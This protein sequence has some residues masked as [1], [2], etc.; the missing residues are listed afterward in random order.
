MQDRFHEEIGKGYGLERGEVGSNAKHRTK[1]QWE[2]EQLKQEFE[3]EKTKLSKELTEEKDRLTAEVQPYRELKAGIDEVDSTGKSMPFGYVAVKK[4]NL[5][6]LQEQAKSD[7]TNRDE[8]ET[9]HERS[10]AVSR[11]EQRADQREQQL[12]QRELGLQNMEQQIIERYNRQLRL[13][14]LLEK[15][16]RD[17]K[18]KD[19]QI[20]DL[21][22]E[23]SSLRGQIRSLTAQVD[24]IKAEL[25]ER[26]NQL[27]DKLRGAYTSLTNIV[28]AVGMLKYDKEDGYKVPDLTQQQEK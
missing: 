12:D 28:K 5:A 21:Q 7:R 10:A 9:L 19:K 3:T 2:A 24:E 27:T 11:K 23:N 6:E 26:I 8:I 1:A 20:A 13:N 15:S 14:Q 18:A 4:E 22:S 16:E 17:G 25:W